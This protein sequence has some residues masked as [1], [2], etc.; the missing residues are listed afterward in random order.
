M[1]IF[2]RLHDFVLAQPESLGWYLLAAVLLV[3]VIS[4]AHRLM[5]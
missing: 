1:T 4:T 3:I 5:K 2:E